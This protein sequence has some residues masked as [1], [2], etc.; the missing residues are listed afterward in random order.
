MSIRINMCCTCTFLV[1]CCMIPT[2]SLSQDCSLEKMEN[3]IVDLKLSLS[4]GIRGTEP[5]YTSTQEACINICCLEKNI[6]G[7]RLCNL[8]IFDARKVSKQP[9]CYLFYCPGKEACPM[10]PAKGLMT[11]RI[12]RGIQTLDS[13]VTNDDTNGN[14]LPSQAALFDLP[15]QA[16]HLNHTAG[17]QKPLKSQMYELRD[18]TEE[19]LHNTELHTQFPE[20]QEKKHPEALDSFPKQQINKLL[21]ARTTATS[22]FSTFTPPVPTTIASSVPKNAATTAQVPTSSAFT[23]TALLTMNFRNA[24]E[25]SALRTSTT[26]IKPI[27]TSTGSTSSI[28]L[29]SL[30]VAA[31][32]RKDFSTSSQNVH[33]DNRQMDSEGFLLGDVPERMHAPQSGDKSGLI[34]ALFFGIVFLLLVITLVGRRMSQ[35]LQ[36]RHYS[37]LDYLI[38]GMYADV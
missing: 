6:L 13:Q 33:Q 37:R 23:T 34:A 26:T 17:L 8:M 19:H 31:L 25:S 9:N 18:E 21:P 29:F 5:I 30:S 15:T 22:Q 27:A 36:R 12:T 10:K 20:D 38:N 28:N 2:P 16:D 14:S 4:H 7:D 35:S 3:I 32:L 24:T 1:M 11:Y